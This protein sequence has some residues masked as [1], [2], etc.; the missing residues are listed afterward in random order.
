MIIKLR[1]ISRILETPLESVSIF[2][3]ASILVLVF[4]EVVSRYIFAAS[5]G[6]M[7]EFSKWAQ[8]WL[9]YLMMGVIEKRRRHLMVDILLS[10]L[11]EKHKQLMSI[12]I[13]TMNLVF[14]IVLCWAGIQGTQF[15]KQVGL[16]STTEIPT[17]M[18]IARLC[19]PIGAI[20]LAFFS[21]EHII[22]DIRSISHQRRSRK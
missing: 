15:V 18:W 9:V 17:P 22:T 7:E 19:I 3:C 14:A 12:L 6:F 21:I 11:S 5:H 2:L 4:A 10:R 13:S 8:V 16:H 1:E 20:F